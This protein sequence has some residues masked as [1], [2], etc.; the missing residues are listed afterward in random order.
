M[1]TKTIKDP[2]E[3]YYVYVDGQ[4]WGTFTISAK[5]DFFIHSD[6]GYWA[7]NWRSF[8]ENFKQFIAGLT[9]D[10]LLTKL[11]SNQRQFHGVNRKISGRQKD[12]ITALFTQFQSELKKELCPQ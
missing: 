7:F 5:G 2:A 6:W 12:A 1:Q 3:Q 9:V 8:G 10:Y 4:S 11:E